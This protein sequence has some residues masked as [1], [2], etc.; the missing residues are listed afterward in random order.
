[1]LPAK[2]DTL[3]LLQTIA[4][5]FVKIGSRSTILTARRIVVSRQ[6]ALSTGVER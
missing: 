4:F 6:V 5:D 1:L 2:H 3:Q